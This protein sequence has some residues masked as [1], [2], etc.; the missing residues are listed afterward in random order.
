MLKSNSPCLSGWS[1]CRSCFVLLTIRTYD[2]NLDGLL[3]SSVHI[4]SAHLAFNSIVITYTA[5]FGKARLGTGCGRGEPLSVE[6]SSSPSP[7][8]DKRA[9]LKCLVRRR[10]RK[11]AWIGLTCPCAYSCPSWDRE[12]WTRFPRLWLRSCQSA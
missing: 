5:R 12:T 2:D 7:S 8:N 1:W 6:T 9:R 4:S 10:R 11:F 3:C